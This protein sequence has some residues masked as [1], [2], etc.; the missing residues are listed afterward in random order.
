MPRT[1]ARKADAVRRVELSPQEIAAIEASANARPVRHRRRSRPR[2]R[3][4]PRP[5][6]RSASAPAPSGSRLHQHQLR[7]ARQKGARRARLRDLPAG[8]EEVDPPRAPSRR[9]RAALVHALSLR[10]ARSARDTWFPIRT[11]HGVERVLAHAG[12][13]ESVP[14]A[15]ID[16]LREAERAGRF[17][18][19]RA[20]ARLSPG[21]RVTVEGGPFGDFV[22]EVATA[23]DGRRVEIL[24]HLFGRLTRMKI[25]LARV[26][27]GMGDGRRCEAAVADRGSSLRDASQLHGE[28]VAIFQPPFMPKF[29][30]WKP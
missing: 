20:P 26:R 23:D 21:D 4:P 3:P 11:T 13:P 18:L 25:D 9:G 22:A 1:T 19:T 28:V 7:A 29:L 10:R 30:G 12:V 2:R 15:V 14:A 16:M 6:C 17:D 27:T 8:D 24:H 5:T